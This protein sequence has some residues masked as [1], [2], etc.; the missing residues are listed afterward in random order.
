[1][2]LL[3]HRG[4]TKTFRELREM[5]AAMDI[6]SDHMLSFLEWS[7][8]VYKKDYALLDDFTDAAAREAALA[9]LKVASEARARV[10]ADMQ[11]AKDAEEERLRLEAEEIERESQLTGVAGKAAFFKRRATVVGTD[12]TKSNEEKI[13]AEAKLRKELREAA[14]MEKAAKEAASKTKSPE[15][16]AR[17]LAE[18]QA[19]EEQRKAEEKARLEAEERAAR[20]ARKAAINAKFASP[21]KAPDKTKSP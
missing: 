16:V 7:C 19:R 1:M 13:K 14:A 5:V 11:A 12:T 6:N 4:E 10:L 21:D 8:A 2:Q 18:V 20:A 17:E 15:E 3:E 9:Q